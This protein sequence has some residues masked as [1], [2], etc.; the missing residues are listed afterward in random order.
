[1]SLAISFFYKVKE[2]KCGVISF[3]FFFALHSLQLGLISNLFFNF[4]KKKKSDV[5]NNY[6]PYSPTMLGK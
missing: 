4:W 3:L 5:Y 6:Y 2:K 1:M